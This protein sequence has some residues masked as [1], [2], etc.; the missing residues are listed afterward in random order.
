MQTRRACASRLRAGLPVAP[1]DEVLD[2][3]ARCAVELTDVGHLAA[4]AT[5]A[6]LLGLYLRSDLLGATGAS[7]SV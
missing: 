7:L 6:R 2:L 1:A 4:A 5:P 3:L